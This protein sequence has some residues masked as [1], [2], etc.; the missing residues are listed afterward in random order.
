MGSSECLAVLPPNWRQFLNG[1]RQLER[2]NIAIRICTKVLYSAAAGIIWP[3]EYCFCHPETISC[4]GELV[5]WRRDLIL[6]SSECLAVL[7]PNRR[8]FL[9]GLWQLKRNNI[10]IRIYT[11]VL[12]RVAA[13]V[14][15]PYEYCFCHPETISCQGKLVSQ[16]RN[17]ILGSSECL[18]VLIPNRRQFLKG[19]RQ[20]KRNNITIRIH[21]KVLYR[22]AADIIWL[23]NSAFALQGPSPVRVN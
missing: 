4:Q 15:W 1:L 19:L 17:P 9:K 11:K 22:V 12:Y 3:Y 7:I 21:T 5:S 13:G 6:G 8:Q 23:A 2:N 18:A 14:I 20:L 16:R 10:T